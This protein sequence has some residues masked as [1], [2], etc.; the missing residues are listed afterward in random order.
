MKHIYCIVIS[1]LIF[2]PSYAQ[3]E[4]E[5]VTHYL[6]PEFTQGVI[7]MK[8][9]KKND[10]LLNYNS[11]TEE[12][13]FERNGKKLAISKTD[14]GIIDTVFIRDRKFIALN[15]TFVE[16][17]Y[18]SKWD[19]YVEHKCKVEKQGKPSGYGGT[20]K[21]SAITSI[22]SLSAEGN[23]YELKLPSNYEIE[24]YTYLWLKKNGELNKFRNMRELK[25]LY[26][27]KEELFKP[28]VK[29]YGVKYDNQESIIQ[30]IEYLE[31]N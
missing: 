17:L 20:S 25:N 24:P 4:N 11:L 26:K 15:S 19:L 2:I 1:C 10:F 7:L 31:S 14:L 8:A 22:A 21:T 27:E 28:Y 5:E 18:H 16:V 30:L 23:F 13:I 29:K 6:F 12:M 9:G 3:P